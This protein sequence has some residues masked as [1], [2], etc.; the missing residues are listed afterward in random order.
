MQGKAD[1]ALFPKEQG[2][3]EADPPPAAPTGF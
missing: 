1:G 2:A 3:E